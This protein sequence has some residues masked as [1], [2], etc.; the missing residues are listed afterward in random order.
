MTV[1]VLDDHEIIRDGLRARL[2]QEPD[3][4]VI[5]EA[6]T[7]TEALA[8]IPQ[9]TPD[10]VILDIQLPDGDGITV[11]REVRSTMKPPPACLMLTSDTDDDA[12]F[13]AIVAGV[14]GYMLTRASSASIVSAVRT[15]A[16][17][18]SLLDPT[19]TAGVMNRLRR[20]AGGVDPRYE[21]LTPQERRILD[22]IAD[23]MTNR[24]IADRLFLAEKTVRNYV[25]SLLA[26]LGLQRRS[27]AAAYGTERRLRQES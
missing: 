6:A 9:L 23:G 15:V 24:Q 10:V 12:L 25:A 5:G 3:I 18:G 11:C 7:A 21:Q 8:R 16:A 19:L 17:G 2:E 13:G 22:H 4:T 14:S 27:A 1:F 20:G 26:K